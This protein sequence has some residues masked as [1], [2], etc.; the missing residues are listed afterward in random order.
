MKSS[1]ILPLVL[2]GFC[3]AAAALAAPGDLL[4]I[5]GDRVNLRQDPSTKAPV[6]LR[7][8]RGHQVFEL[9]RQGAW[10]NVGIDGG[11]GR[12]G[13]VHGSLVGPQGPD[14]MPA[15]P[16]DPRFERFR[17]GV[18]AL[19]AD[20]AQADGEIRFTAASDLGDGIVRVVATDAW[21]AGAQAARQKDMDA[22]FDLWDAAEGTGLP[23]MVQV[24]DPAGN[25]VM[26]RARR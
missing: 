8:D 12:D 6:I 13:W 22:L 7:L 1:L 23:I 25:V 5:Q 10:V 21:A 19:N 4:Y 18:L 14:G 9:Q 11:G 17:S 3:C 2:G 24:V 26:T 16:A 20:A 15:S